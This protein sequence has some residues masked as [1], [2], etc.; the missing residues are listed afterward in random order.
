MSLTQIGGGEFGDLL[1]I[2][3]CNVFYLRK[4]KLS[5]LNEN[6]C[7]VDLFIADGNLESKVYRHSIEPR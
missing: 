7:I 5:L 6:S 3:W 2:V 4:I 1:I